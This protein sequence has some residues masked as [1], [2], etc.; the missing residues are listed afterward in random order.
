MISITKCNTK[1]MVALAMV[2]FLCLGAFGVMAADEAQADPVA[3]DAFAVVGLEGYVAADAEGD[4]DAQFLAAVGAIQNTVVYVA[5][6]NDDI[7]ETITITTLKY[8]EAL[9]DATFA[10]DGVEIVEDTVVIKAGEVASNDIVRGLG[11]F[12]SAVMT[13]K[14]V[15][16]GVDTAV[17]LGNVAAANVIEKLDTLPAVASVDVTGYV[18]EIT[19][20]EQQV[21]IL[22]E[23]IAELEEDEDERIAELEDEIAELEALIAEKNL[24]LE[25]DIIKIADL[26]KQL[27]DAQKAK[28]GD[29][30]TAWCIAALGLIAAGVLGGFTVLA[31]NKAKKE[32]RRLI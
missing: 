10:A 27:E 20:L 29:S 25:A 18:V 4:E 15:T 32:G 11:L 9:T 17:I 12:T 1:S 8:Y 31:A 19:L 16:G 6:L 22:E 2:A 21:A 3:V 26:E 23:R 24:A 5:T 7:E 13:A 30:T 14:K 28:G